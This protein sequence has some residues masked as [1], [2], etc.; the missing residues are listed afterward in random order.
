M[1][2]SSRKIPKK[3]LPILVAGLLV[4][5]VTAVMVPLT[6]AWFSN[7]QPSGLATQ[8]HGGGSPESASDISR[9]GSIFDRGYRELAVSF[10]MKSLYA[11]PLEIGN[12]DEAAGLLAD[13]MGL[14]PTGLARKLKAERSFV[15][16][17]RGLPASKADGILHKGLPGIYA[18]EEARR[19]YP[20]LRSGAHVVG[21]VEEN[22]PLA[23]VEFYYDHTLR[24]GS[25]G[26]EEGA[27]LASHLQL[28][29]DLRIQ[30][31]LAAEL[32]TLLRR[33]GAPYGTGIVM[34]YK[35][36]AVL[37]MASLPDYDP[38]SYWDAGSGGH[39]N[40]AVNGSI[41]L[42]GF[43]ALFEWAAAHETA[44]E[45]SRDRLAAL[46]MDL[47]I[48]S[49]TMEGPRSAKWFERRGDD[50]LSP[51]FGRWR[52][53]LVAGKEPAALIERLGL[54]RKSGIDL[55]ETDD[56]TGAESGI[57]TPLKLLTAF[58][59]LVNGGK[60]VVPYLGE[61]IIDPASGRRQV[62]DRSANSSELLRPA[63]SRKIVELLAKASRSGS[64]TIFLESLRPVAAVAGKEDAGLE[65]QSSEEP[66]SETRYQTVLLGFEP[67]KETG[68]A[69]LVA[70]DRAVVDPEKKTA[71]RDMGEA[72][73]GRMAILAADPVEQPGPEAMVAAEEHL[74]K[75]WLG[76]RTIARRVAKV[77]DVDHQAKPPVVMPDLRGLSLRR[78]LRDLQ[79]LEVR[80][81]IVGSGRVVEQEP[82]AGLVVSGEDCRLALR[83]EQ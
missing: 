47:L 57:T 54:F 36:G 2:R 63:T 33:T 35:T 27:G 46:K 62:I 50:L 19:F 59:V 69:L 70:L 15:W 6:R 58:G 21:F 82:A 43:S 74:F 23:G 28:T 61:A 30:E 60:E 14:D 37:A 24:R 40:R 9:Q 41:E 65:E 18:V 25:E 42:G 8:E 7:D 31:L 13:E 71:M 20:A 56:A 26:V 10:M 16:L 55:P 4:L 51:E 32:A 34:N 39:L 5:L 3:S 17:A 67:R 66:G 68:L 11:R 29:L 53:D 22:N 79:T 77:A 52:E 12:I 72:V 81:E 80:V 1:R 44:G 73:L 75:A 48:D 76:S 49:R 64:A 83:A 38:N 45:D 78:A